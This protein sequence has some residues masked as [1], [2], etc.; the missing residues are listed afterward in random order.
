MRVAVVG[1]GGISK[2]HLDALSA[3]EDVE[4]S[5]VTDIRLERAGAAAEKYGCSAYGDFREMLDADA[6]EA[7]HICTPHYLHVPM[8]VEALGR[9]IHVL[10]EK[11]CAIKADELSRLR[12]AQSMS[13]AVYGVCFQNR[14]NGSVKTVMELLQQGKYGR[15]ITA[16]ACVHWFRDKEYY[17]DDWHGTLEREGG[18]VMVNQAVHTL[19]LMRYL[20]GG[21]IA[22][23]DAHVAN[24]HLRDVIE[25]EDTADARFV[26]EDGTV[27]LFSASTAFGISSDIIIDLCCEKAT[28]RIEGDNVFVLSNGEVEVVHT[29]GADNGIAGKSYWG[30]SHGA[31]INDFYD[32]IK[33]GRKFPID[34]YEGG[35]AVEEFLAV[36][37][38]SETGSRVYLER[39]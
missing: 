13:S 10:S 29:A 38:S 23:V 6:P 1:C 37:R 27:A 35:K 18:G 12:L 34:S 17:S 7:V 28:I 19:D 25:V 22:Y 33:T 3:M 14:Y 9:G 2:C 36:Y 8:A 24:Y 39:K 15:I 11:P 4:I 32:C 16:R 5:S 30:T 31:L 20:I 26:F 21:R